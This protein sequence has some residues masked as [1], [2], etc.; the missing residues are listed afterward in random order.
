LLEGKGVSYDKH[1]MFRVGRQMMAILA[2]VAVFVVGTT[3]T[4]AGCVIPAEPVRAAAEHSCCATQANP[5]DSHRSSPDTPRS[6]PACEHPLFAGDGA[7]TT[8]KS[9]GHSHV[10]LDLPALLLAPLPLSTYSTG[11]SC[12]LTPCDGPPPHDLSTRLALSCAL[13][14]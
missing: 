1:S 13:L 10:P 2:A 12:R 11:P 6:C 14:N 4:R 8:A 5:P 3:C 9:V 7:N